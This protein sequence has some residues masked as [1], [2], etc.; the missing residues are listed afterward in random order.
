MN[1]DEIV[2]GGAGGGSELEDNVGVAEQCQSVWGQQQ[3][4]CIFYL[5]QKP[6]SH[7]WYYQSGL[8]GVGAGAGVPPPIL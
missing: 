8:K 4:G 2:C 7:C 5:L 3:Q 1:L 6:F